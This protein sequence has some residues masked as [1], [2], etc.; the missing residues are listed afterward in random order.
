MQAVSFKFKL[1]KNN[2]FIEHFKNMML[3][4]GVYN[5]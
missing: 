1:I 5:C 2:T 4:S 3:I